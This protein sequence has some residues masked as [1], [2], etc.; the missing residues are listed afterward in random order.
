MTQGARATGMGLAFAGVAD[1]P[2][3][4]FY[5]PA[6]LGWQ[7]HFS[8]S[9]NATFLTRTD[10]GVTGANP[11]PGDGVVETIQNQW[12]VIPSA[13]G[14]IPLT[15]ELNF[16]VGA[17]AQYGLGLRWDDPENYSGRFISQNAVIKSTDLN[18]V[19]SYRLLPSLAIAAGADLRFSGLQLERNQGRVDPL[20]GAVV[21]TAHTKL[22]SGL[23][24]N[25]GW[26]W[27]AGI[28]FKPFEALSIGG[29]YRSGIKVDYEGDATFIQ[30]F[31]GDPVFDALVTAGLPPDQ[32]V[33]T[34]IDFPASVNI[35][36]GIRLPAGL[37]LALEADWT[38]WS[39]FQSLVINFPE[40]PS[41][42]FSRQ[43][44]WEDSW[45]YRVGLE[46]KIG[47]AWALRAGYYYDNTPQPDFDVSPLLADNDR[48]VYSAGF[49]Y[50]TERFG[51]DVGALLIKFKDRAILNEPVT[52]RYFGTY[53]ETG[54]VLT[55]GIRLAM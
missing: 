54:L 35:G 19:F 34:A 12:F 50:G 33:A 26:G 29:A 47:E 49:G 24:S 3:A 45:A 18:A 43:T 31:T 44:Q 38:E 42:D 1:D 32:P 23:L 41:L 48:N 27:N 6:G 36:M 13:Y 37:L 51:V 28:M 22:Y 53:S 14:V 9:V 17:F 10:G 11:Y 40:Q 46:W 52:S 15:E 39:S 5:N 8:A 4:V 25:T 7:P 30:R 2:T 55:A 21:D 20:T 16:G